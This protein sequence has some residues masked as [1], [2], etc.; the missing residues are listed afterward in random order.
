MNA[1]ITDDRD[2]WEK[3]YVGSVQYI[4]TYL[5]NCTNPKEVGDGLAVANNECILEARAVYRY[6][7]ELFRAR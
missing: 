2:E 6:I 7:C 3:R 5:T 4:P 1:D